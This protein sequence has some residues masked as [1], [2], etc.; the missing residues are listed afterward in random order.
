MQQAGLVRELK[1]CVLSS[2][3]KMWLIAEWGNRDDYRN[4]AQGLVTE[5]MESHYSLL[6]CAVEQTS[7][8]RENCVLEWKLIASID[9]VQNSSMN[10]DVL[11]AQFAA[12]QVRMSLLAS[13]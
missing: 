8:Q 5:A 4:C 11:S 7:L 2:I 10:F 9:D 3:A 12:T 13:P 1:R 6:S